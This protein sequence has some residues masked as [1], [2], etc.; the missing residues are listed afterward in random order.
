M[1]GGPGYNQEVFATKFVAKEDLYIVE[2]EVLIR[3]FLVQLLSYFYFA[4]F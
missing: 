4:V 3:A 1:E 2:K